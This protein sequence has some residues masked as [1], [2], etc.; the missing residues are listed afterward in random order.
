MKCTKR[1]VIR[2]ARYHT[3]VK[4]SEREFKGH[5]IFSP[6][7]VAAIWNRLVQRGLPHGA[8]LKHLLWFLYFLK[9]YITKEVGGKFTDCNR[10]TFE[11]W[12]KQMGVAASDLGKVR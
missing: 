3:G 5:F 2:V 6:A 7:V 9:Y 1:T 11:K 4:G 8:Q 12:T 10:D